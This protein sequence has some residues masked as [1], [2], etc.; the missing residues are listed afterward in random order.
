MRLRVNGVA[1]RWSSDTLECVARDGDV[2]VQLQP[3]RHQLTV[4]VDGHRLETWIQVEG[5]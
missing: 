1:A 2:F 5:L 3:G 4:E